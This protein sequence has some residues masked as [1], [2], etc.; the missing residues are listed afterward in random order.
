MKIDINNKV[1]EINEKAF[2]LYILK[3]II[4]NLIIFNNIYI[5]L[6]S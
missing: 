4:N 3:I 5:Y 2:Y 6:N 1:E